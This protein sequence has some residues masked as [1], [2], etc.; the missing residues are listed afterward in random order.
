MDGTPNIRQDI[1]DVLQQRQE[2][3]ATRHAVLEALSK[4]LVLTDIDIADETGRD[5]EVIRET[6]RELSEWDLVELGEAP[7]GHR[8]LHSPETPAFTC[9]LIAI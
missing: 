1:V 6:L 7:R 8:T 4:Q 9:R 2:Q 3:V 5:I